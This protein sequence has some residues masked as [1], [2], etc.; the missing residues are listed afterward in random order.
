MPERDLDDA[1]WVAC[2]HA[3]Q[4][5]VGMFF[6]GKKTVAGATSGT[7][8]TSR[9]RAYQAALDQG[10]SSGFVASPRRMGFA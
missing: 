2:R 9:L 3:A 4:Q 7:S 8:G 10:Q 1:G 5:R 6:H